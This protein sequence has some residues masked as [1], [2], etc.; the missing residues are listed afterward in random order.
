[1]T[2]D[3]CV[4]AAID[5]VH[6]NCMQCCIPVQVSELA[7]NDAACMPYLKYVISGTLPASVDNTVS[8]ATGGAA[9]S[10]LLKAS[11]L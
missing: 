5:G 7:L 1:V 10:V 9:T 6:H 3:A 11:A 2:C 8:G 4:L